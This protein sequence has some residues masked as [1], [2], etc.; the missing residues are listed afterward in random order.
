M[1]G[2]HVF[3]P[4]KTSLTRG[5]NT[6]KSWLVALL[7]AA[8]LSPWPHRLTALTSS[9]VTAKNRTT[10]AGSSPAKG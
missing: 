1:E 7:S 8:L 4:D 2:C 9:F 3:I 6:M 10:T 5:K